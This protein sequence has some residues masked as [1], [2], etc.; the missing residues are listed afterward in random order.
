MALRVREPYAPAALD[1]GMKA[2]ASW[3]SVSVGWGRVPLTV[4]ARSSTTLAVAAATEGVSLVPLMVT[5]R[6]LEPVAP[7]LSLTV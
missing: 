1:W 6:V 2:T 4:G 5:V 7:W 3:M